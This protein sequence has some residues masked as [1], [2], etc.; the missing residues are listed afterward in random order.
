M[1]DIDLGW[2]AGLLE[3]EG[4]FSPVKRTRKSGE[5][6]LYLRIQIN[7]T[8]EDVI[9][10]LHEVVGAGN[11]TGPRLYKNPDWKP[12]WEWTLLGDKAEALMKEVYPYLGERR[13]EQIDF[14]LQKVWS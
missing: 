14:V 6:Y 10:R 3:G 13:R 8:D 7:M 2:V 12:R 1:R 4:C 5:K 11:V 9:R